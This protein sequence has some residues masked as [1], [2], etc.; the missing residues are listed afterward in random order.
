MES[1][2]TK[3][4]H[5]AMGTFRVPLSQNLYIRKVKSSIGRK[6]LTPKITTFSTETFPY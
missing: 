2:R 6:S 1:R 4:E 3:I 5:F